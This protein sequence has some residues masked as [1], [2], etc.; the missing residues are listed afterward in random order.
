MK[1][2]NEKNW[3]YSCKLHTITISLPSLKK[4]RKLE[5]SGAAVKTESFT[6]II[7]NSKDM[8]AT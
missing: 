3:G 2:E 1:G 7:Y 6:A 5:A 8:E 4:P